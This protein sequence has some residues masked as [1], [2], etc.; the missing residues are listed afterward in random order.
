MKYQHYFGWTEVMMMMM[1][2]HLSAVHF[3]LLLHYISGSLGILNNILPFK[4]ILDLFCPSYK[5][6]LSQV[7]LDV[8]FPSRFRP[9]HYLLVDSF[10]LYIFLT[11]LVS[12]ILF[13]CPN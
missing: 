3:L 9:S 4:V 2:N 10:H 6:H 13:M 5:F 1:M 12:G 7:I 8:V 11:V